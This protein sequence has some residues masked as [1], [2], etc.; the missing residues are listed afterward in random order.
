MT[1]TR[2][3]SRWITAALAAGAAL[4]EAQ[5]ASAQSIGVR[6]I[7]IEL[8]RDQ[9]ASVLNIT[10]SGATPTTIQIRGFAWRQVDGKDQLDPTTELAVSPPFAQIAPGQ[11]QLV[12]LVL[13][14]PKIDHEATYR[15][16]ID[17]VPQANADGV[18]LAVRISIPIFAEMSLQGQAKLDWKMVVHANGDGELI[19]NN[20]GIRHARVSQI[21]VTFPGRP[22][23]SI[24]R[25]AFGYV[26]PQV[27]RTWKVSG[28]TDPSSLAQ[29]HVT[30]M[31]DHGPVDAAATVTTAP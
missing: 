5:A 21:Q 24:E 28:L 7:S 31:S 23:I 25:G 15:V 19:A 9:H 20:S 1:Q 3:L 30:A 12:R 14:T 6:P 11:T 16:I 22:P 29:A 27:Q 17:Q 4:L 2:R 10:N 13:R 8:A 18:K 26:L